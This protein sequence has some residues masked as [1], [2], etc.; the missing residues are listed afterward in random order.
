MSK[1]NY[2]KILEA[3]TKRAEGMGIPL[4]PNSFVELLKKKI[5]EAKN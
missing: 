3:F 5:R 1:E 2:E 4:N